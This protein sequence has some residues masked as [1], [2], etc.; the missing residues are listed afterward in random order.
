[1]KSKSITGIKVYNMFIFLVYIKAAV[2]RDS[3]LLL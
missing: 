3:G 1:M 2:M